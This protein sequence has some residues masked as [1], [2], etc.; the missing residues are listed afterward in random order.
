MKLSIE[1]VLKKMVFS[2]ASDLYIKVGRPPVMRVDG[3]LYPMKTDELKEEDITYFANCIMNESQKAIFAQTMELDTAYTIPEV[4]RFRVNIFKQRGSISMVFRYV[5]KLNLSFE[6]LNLPPIVRELA[7]SP[8]GL[9][10]VTGTAGSGKSTTLAAMINHINHTRK[11]HIV[12]IEDPIEFVFEDDL[13]IIQQRE[14][15]QDTLSFA[16]ALRRVVRQSPDVIMIGEMRDLETISAAIS[17]AETGHLVLSTLHTIDTTTTVERIINF[18][19]AHLQQQVRMELALCLRGVISLR[20]LTRASGVG[21]IPA[22]E[23]MVV[24]PSI[25][26]LLLEG[27]T[28][29]LIKFIEEGELF[30][31]QTFNQAL[32]KLYQRNLITYEEALQYASS[33]DE[34]KLQVQGISSQTRISF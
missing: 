25:R 18:F 33:P 27:R 32:A 9:I 19:P 7:E 15:G 23:V 26:K 5:P 3:K 6:E 13:S 28:T 2:N 17:A 34:F 20:L 1:E 30:G 21:R 10:L 4:G 12:T 11:C 31:M 16:E 14:V 8:R 22:V 24:T 29:E